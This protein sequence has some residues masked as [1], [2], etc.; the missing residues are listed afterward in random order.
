MG[1]RW[2]GYLSLI[3]ST[4]EATTKN[5]LY[6]GSM[7]TKQLNKQNKAKNRNLRGQRDGCHRGEEWWV[8]EISE[9]EYS[10]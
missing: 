7:K 5:F 6:V 3:L 2:K 1:G 10:Q 4:S 8:G 9:G